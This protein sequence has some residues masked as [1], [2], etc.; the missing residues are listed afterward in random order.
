VASRLV[1]LTGGLT[2]LD[3]AMRL[4]ARHTLM[5]RVDSL[6]LGA[7]P[8]AG[9][10]AAGPLSYPGGTLAGRLHLVLLF[11]GKLLFDRSIM[12]PPTLILPQESPAQ[13]YSRLLY[14]T[15]DSVA[16]ELTRVLQS[17]PQVPLSPPASPG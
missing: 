11:D 6:V 7:S 8:T 14:A 12:M 3:E 15:M 17:S 16:G 13:A 10:G 2:A 1:G 4:G 5:V 9:P